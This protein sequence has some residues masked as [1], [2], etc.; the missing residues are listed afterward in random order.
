MK[1]KYVV[2]GIAAS[3]LL[4]LGLVA[5]S[6]QKRP[7][8]VAA[9]APASGAVVV[10]V[11]KVAEQFISDDLQ[12][13]GSILSNES[14]VLRPEIAGR[15]VQINFSEGQLVQQGQVLI[16]LD[17]S[18]LRAEVQQAEAQLGLA[19]TNYDRTVDL[20]RQGFVS[21]SAR[22]Q[23]QAALKVQEATRALAQAQ[24][25][26]TAIRAP[27]SGVVGVRSVAP[28]DYVSAGKDLVTLED[29]GSMKIEFRIPE[30]Y[31]GQV[32]VGQKFVTETDAYVGQPFDATVMLIDP[33]LDANARSV[34][35]RGRVANPKALLK[36]GMFARV[37][38]IFG[39]RKA[40]L[41]V[42]EE[43]V[44]PAGGKNFVLRVVDGKAIRTEVELGLR[45]GGIV[46]VR[47][48]VALADSVIVAGQ[49]KVR[50]TDVPVQVTERV[51][52]GVTARTTP[53]GAT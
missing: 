44:V 33:R 52:P 53:K 25:A 2:W 11:A 47:N 40:A 41:V 3:G 27:F 32:R 21:E 43:A 36:P 38:L 6:L 26:K 34:L 28:G 7:A 51:A 20:A 31:L 14:V 37:R 1:K 49:M 9:V 22:D 42:P 5:Y 48:G 23:S 15:V 29:I 18:V 46:E 4:A 16:G 19:R 8:P 35:V 39:E 30:R 17:D 50:G 24:F 10:E 45:R 12:A 13:V